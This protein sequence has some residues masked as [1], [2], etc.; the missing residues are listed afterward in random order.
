VDKW[1]ESNII[2]GRMFIIIRDIYSLVRN[3]VTFEDNSP[4][5]C[6]VEDRKTS[7]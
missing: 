5:A 2:F 3:S 1:C 4:R 7:G 6:L